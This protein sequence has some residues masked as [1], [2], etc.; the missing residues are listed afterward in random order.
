[1]GFSATPASES[2]KLETGFRDTSVVF[3]VGMACLMLLVMALMLHFTTKAV[4]ADYA[5]LYSARAI[6]I[7]NS[8]LN[9]EIALMRKAVQSAAIV[10]WFAAEDNY[11]KK[12]SAY[13]EM[14][15]LMDVLYSSNLYFGVEK[16]RNEYSMDAESSFTEFAPFSLLKEDRF[17]DKWY[18][19]CLK[20]ANDYKLNVDID[21]LKRRK[22]VWL[23]YKIVDKGTVLGVLATGL[24]FDHVIDEIFGEYDKNN[25][26][27]IV[28]DEKGVIQM[29]SAV[30]DGDKL[31]FESLRTLKDEVKDPAFSAVMDNHLAAISGFFAAA[32]SPTVVELSG[33]RYGYVAIA[34]IEATN[35][36]VVTFYNSSSLFSLTKLWPLFLVMLA[37]LVVYSLAF[38]FMTRKFIFSPFSS[39]M[40][41]IAKMGAGPAGPIYGTERD[42]E[43]GDLAR[44][45][46]DMKNRLDSYNCE[47]VEAMEQAERASRAKS[48]FLANMSHEMRTPMNAIIGMA[49]IARDTEDVEKMRYCLGKID[50]ASAHLLGVINDI[51][52]MSK[53]ESGKFEIHTASFHF[54][55]MLRRIAG[56][57]NFRM[58]E[59]N[60]R[61]SL[62]VDKHI[63]EYI[64]ADEQ[65][66][67][68]V[69]TN[70]LS[71]AEKFTPENGSVALSAVYRE[72]GRS[73]GRVKIAVTD[74]GIGISTENQ[75]KLF[76]S[77]EQA[78][79]GISR[80]YGGTGLGLAIS[81]KIVELMGGTI[82][83][84]SE[85]GK[86]SCFF[87]EIPVI[88]G[89]EPS[90]ESADAGAGS[91]PARA[92]FPGRRVLLA[93]DIEVNR[94]VLVALLADSG[95][96]F[97]F[98]EN[99][100]RAVELFGQAPESYDMILMD[101]QMPEMDGYE[102]TRAIRAMDVP[103]AGTIPIIAMTANA[104]RED[105]E[106]S[107]EA[108]MDGHLGKPVDLEE[109]YA[110]FNRYF[111]GMP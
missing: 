40:G 10:E 23:N 82:S 33:G 60:L 38:G 48:E 56:V 8:H 32:V 22:L 2:R 108:G 67:A 34:P 37:V 86:G 90:V 102:A 81:K 19:E 20:S 26:R 72:E 45:V 100:L 54:G 92:R 110:V 62:S 103:E 63:P 43:L 76:R 73:H 109:L 1:M 4:S 39:L 46:R 52:D 78:D 68:Q 41:S 21:K 97:V 5:R 105:V 74:S 70:L 31:I 83:L 15:S 58:S 35:W 44:T 49:R 61:F 80:K 66:L 84:E 77:F 75:E 47:L 53:I 96:E 59:K 95:L 85:P 57:L 25:V 18:F 93:E 98:A 17:T 107:R 87:F 7:L 28:I 64:V 27:G 101:V 6:G 79:G 36:T 71:N 11:G 65:R 3:F 9:R 42:D 29:D 30:G 111:S 91:G 89:S 69:I 24:Q 55:K 94:E 51:L 106:R 12:I 99:G 104:F 14:K 16:S 13:Q 88:R 50:G